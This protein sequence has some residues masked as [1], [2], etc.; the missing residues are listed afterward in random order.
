MSVW[1]KPHPMYMVC[2]SDMIY[3]WYMVY[4]GL[5]MIHGLSN[6]HGLPICVVYWLHHKMISHICWYMCDMTRV[7]DATGSKGRANPMVSKQHQL[8]NGVESRI[9]GTQFNLDSS[10]SCIRFFWN[11]HLKYQCLDF[12]TWCNTWI[13]CGGGCMKMGLCRSNMPCGIMGLWIL[14]QIYGTI[15]RLCP[16]GDLRRGWWPRSERGDVCNSGCLLVSALL[17]QSS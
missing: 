12:D 6:I 5:P 16:R 1:H 14:L 7:F 3:P 17:I 4:H 11:V 15:H 10:G 8:S 2:P 13:N 9:G